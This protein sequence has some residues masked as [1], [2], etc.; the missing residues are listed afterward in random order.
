MIWTFR[1]GFKSLQACL[2]IAVAANVIDVVVNDDDD[3][4]HTIHRHK[5]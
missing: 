1:L 5:C 4:D 2:I 3:D